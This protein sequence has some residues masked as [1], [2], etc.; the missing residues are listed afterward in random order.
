MICF[1]QID[2]KSIRFIYFV[3]AYNHYLSATNHQ[4]TSNTLIGVTE[5]LRA[6]CTL[7]ALISITLAYD[8]DR[9]FSSWPI[10][11]TGTRYDTKNWLWIG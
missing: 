1:Y 9:L 6:A 8:F 5:H 2:K 3:L 4:L 7:E 11:N 10:G